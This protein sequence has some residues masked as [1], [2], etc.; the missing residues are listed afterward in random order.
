MNDWIPPL[1]SDATPTQIAAILGAMRAV[2]DTETP[3]SNNDRRAIA[4]ARRY[5][6][7]DNDASNFD[8]LKPAT[9]EELAAA[10]AGTKLNENAVKFITVMALIDGKLDRAKI[11]S[12]LSYAGALGMHQHYIDQIN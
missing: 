1:I 11:A 7:G 2:A 4:S 3:A 12:V 6:F 8:T 10:L 9:P 5:I